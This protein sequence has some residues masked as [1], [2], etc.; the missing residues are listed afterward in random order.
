MAVLGVH[1][2]ERGDAHDVRDLR[3]AAVASVD[4]LVRGGAAAVLRLVNI[5]ITVDDALRL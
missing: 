5:R 4:G 2:R 1:V 3:D